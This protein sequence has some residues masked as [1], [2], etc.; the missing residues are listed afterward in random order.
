MSPCGPATLVLVFTVAGCQTH[1]DASSDREVRDAHV[2]GRQLTLTRDV[3]LI[4]V[5]DDRYDKDDESFGHPPHVFYIRP[6]TPARRVLPDGTVYVNG[7]PPILTVPRGTRLRV[8]RVTYNLWPPSHSC[9]LVYA[10]FLDGPE[11]GLETKV[12][13]FHPDSE[14]QLEIWPTAL[15]PADYP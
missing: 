2:I 6:R 10:Q 14:R 4:E 11:T 1:R 7:P 8:T 5:P 13:R 15:R 9:Y 12:G 3:S